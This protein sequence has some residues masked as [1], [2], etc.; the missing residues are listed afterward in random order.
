MT[1]SDNALLQQWHAGRDA[2]AF[3]ELVS[4]HSGMVFGTCRRILGNAADAE[5][6]TQECFMDLARSPAGV[7]SPGGWLHTVAVRRALDR[8]KSEQRRRRREASAAFPTA[9]YDRSDW[10]EIRAHVDEA[11]ASL[12]AELR[13]P[14]VLRFLE[15]RTH[16]AVAEQLGLP[17]STAE[18]RLNRGLQE[19]RRILRKR[20]VAPS[21]VG[22][23]GL[24][25]SRLA[26]TAS[27]ELTAALGRLSLAAME[28]GA[29][30]L[31]GAAGASGTAK[32]V[33]LGLAAAMVI[34]AAAYG[35]KAGSPE[36]GVS[37]PVPVSVVTPNA[38][39]SG[40]AAPAPVPAAPNSEIRQAAAGAGVPAT[41]S[42][43]RREPAAPAPASPAS[44]VPAS[45]TPANVVPAAAGSPMAEGEARRPVA[46]S[47][48]A[49]GTVLDP[50]GKPCPGIHVELVEL[51]LAKKQGKS[52]DSDGEG[53]FLFEGLKTGVR[54]ALLAVDRSAR[55]GFHR[56][57]V[58]TLR[59]GGPGYAADLRLGAGPDLVG[60]VLDPNGKPAPSA[61]VRLIAHFSHQEGYLSAVSLSDCAIAKTDAQGR[62]RIRGVS[63]GEYRLRA[64]YNGLKNA[65]VGTEV[66]VPKTVPPPEVTVRLLAAGTGEPVAR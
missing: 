3:A 61:D 25:G 22:L 31:A 49:G 12:P 46:R 43:E 33:L 32:A 48:T 26:E 63:P 45:P 54:Y 8:R 60:Q 28:P 41:P 10:D 27:P 16:E 29:G 50:Q 15:G 13:E 56:T 7:Q 44:A 2:D 20:G 62:F 42:T 51:S 38:E 30:L 21:L 35:I 59:S 1:S 65:H 18:S 19:L 17:R 14:V 11:I 36:S 52:L 23:E 47:G 6:V 53:G 39:P 5:E 40:T 55:L 57:G 66:R 58:F 9:R 24:L 64:E 4:R 37:V 34:F